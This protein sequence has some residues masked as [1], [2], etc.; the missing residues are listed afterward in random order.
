MRQGR[1]RRD[2]RAARTS[3]GRRGR[4]AARGLVAQESGGVGGRRATC[5]KPSGTGGALCDLLS[6]CEECAQGARGRSRCARSV[7]RDR[8]EARPSDRWRAVLYEEARDIARRLGDT[9]AEARI[10]ATFAMAELFAGRVEQGL[11]R[12]EAAAKTAGSSTDRALSVRLD[13][14]I[15]YMYILSGRVKE[16]LEVMDRVVAE[17]RGGTLAEPGSGEWFSRVSRPSTFLL[18]AARR[19]RGHASR[20]HRACAEQQRSRRASARCAASPSPSRGSAATRSPRSRM[21]KS[22]CE[23][24]SGCRRRRCSPAPTIRWASRAS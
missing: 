6:R 18:G 17:Q 4:H 9:A 7:D 5:A 19:G 13:G 16:A 14:R 3:L 11:Q 2:G 24:P 8:L 12:L 20:G 21:R 22:R 10:A 15:A 23:S 1:P